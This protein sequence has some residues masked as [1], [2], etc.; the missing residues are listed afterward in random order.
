MLHTS[1]LNTK[2]IML[3]IGKETPLHL[4]KE[5]VDAGSVSSVTV[6]GTGDGLVVVAMVGMQERVLSRQQGGPRF[7]NTVDGAVSV[8]WKAGVRQFSVDTSNWSPAA[9]VARAA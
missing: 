2:P 8:L 1:T 3:N 9:Q 4:F 6:R 5:L 7:F